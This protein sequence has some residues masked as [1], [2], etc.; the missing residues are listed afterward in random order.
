MLRDGQFIK[1]PPVK[2]GE[3]WIPTPKV[4]MT[5]DDELIQEALLAQDVNFWQRLMRSMAAV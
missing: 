2:I 4:A 5:I 1:E 3:Y